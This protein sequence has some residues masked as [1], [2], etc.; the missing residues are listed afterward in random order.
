MR[1][2]EKRRTREKRKEKVKLY[3]N[4]HEKNAWCNYSN[5][6]NLLKM[7]EVVLLRSALFVLFGF[8]FF[9]PHYW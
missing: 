6:D 8:V 2:K 7:F 1:R 5:H 3:L 4:I 9:V